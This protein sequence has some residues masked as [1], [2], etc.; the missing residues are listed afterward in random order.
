MSHSCP[1]R[2]RSFWSVPWPRLYSLGT[3]VR[4]YNSIVKPVQL[5]GAE[6][7]QVVKG[8]T[9]KIDAFHNRCLRRIC[10]I[11]WPNKT[12]NEELHKMTKSQSMVSEIKCRRIAWL[13]HVLRMDQDRILKTA[14]RW[15]PP[16]K[17]K[18]GQPR[19][20]WRRTVITELKEMGLTMGE[21]QYTA[22]D[23]S[24]WRQII[25]ALCP[26]WDEED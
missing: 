26:T 19:M 17:R 6:C 12:S 15:T 25:D 10:R 13:G 4:L 18:Q 24:Q 14:L 21:A 23:R 1:L 11:F 22:K 5:Y 2:L 7:W 16:G 8:D 20:T 9:N 3:E